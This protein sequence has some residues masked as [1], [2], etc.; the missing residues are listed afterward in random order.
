[1]NTKAQIAPTPDAYAPGYKHK[2][3][4]RLDDQLHKLLKTYV[5]ENNTTVQAFLESLVRQALIR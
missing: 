4:V 2:V 5:I 3:H 1:M